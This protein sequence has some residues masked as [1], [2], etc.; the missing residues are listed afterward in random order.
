MDKIERIG[1]IAANETQRLDSFTR[2]LRKAYEDSNQDKNEIVSGAYFCHFS[3]VVH[4][5][6]IE[7]AGINIQNCKGDISPVSYLPFD[8]E[9]IDMIY[10]SPFV[11][12]EDYEFIK[13]K[14]PEIEY[15]VYP[16]ALDGIVTA[17]DYYKGL[18]RRNADARKF[19]E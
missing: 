16:I 1:Y 19:I 10:L 6:K 13:S 17:D 3:W 7:Y 5:N 2:F 8:N 9:H 15:F 12:L 11:S 14:N 18:N 4:T